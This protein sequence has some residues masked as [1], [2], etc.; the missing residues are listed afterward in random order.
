MTATQGEAV[1][2]NMARKRQRKE[3]GECLRIITNGEELIVEWFDEA[4]HRSIGTR[5]IRDLEDKG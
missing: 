1:G 2:R 3:D 5:G 4:Q